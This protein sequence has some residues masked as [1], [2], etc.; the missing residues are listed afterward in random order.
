M[1]LVEPAFVVGDVITDDH[2]QVVADLR[3]EVAEQARMRGQAQDAME[4]YRS[5]A[6]IQAGS[7]NGEVAV[8]DPATVQDAMESDRQLDEVMGIVRDAL[9][10]LESG[11][12]ADVQR[13]VTSLKAIAARA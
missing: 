11:E 12:R 7:D 9:V 13:A 8:A 5:E 3:G 1:S 10:D 4:Q 2:A 6:E